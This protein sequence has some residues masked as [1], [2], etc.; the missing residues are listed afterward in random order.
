AAFDGSVELQDRVVGAGA[1]GILAEDRHPAAG[2]DLFS[3]RVGEPTA[4]GQVVT[5]D[6]P[7]PAASFGGARGVR[8]Q[9]MSGGEHEIAVD[10][11]ARAER[12]ARLVGEA[13]A[14]AE[15]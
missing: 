1:T 9:A 8:A 2:V 3:A 12:P 7:R 15:L 14:R 5:E 6:E 11:R 10:Q 4:L 13:L